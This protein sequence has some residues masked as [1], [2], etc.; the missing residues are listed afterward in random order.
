M[1]R[2]AGAAAA[3]ARG[4]GTIAAL[5]LFIVLA[6]GGLRRDQ[7]AELDRLRNAG[8]RTRHCVLFVA[9][10]SGWLC[11]A[12]LS[13]GAAVG[14]GAAALLAR[15][16]GEPAGAILT[17][18]VITPQGRSRWD[19]VARG[20]HAAQRAG[21]GAQ[22]EADRRA[23]G[24]GGVGPGGS[25]GREHRPRPRDGAAARA[26]VLCSR[27]GADVS[28]RSGGAAGERNAW[29]G[30]ARCSRASRSSISPAPPRL[31]ALVIAFIAV[32]DGPRRL[33]PRLP[34]DADPQR[35]RPGGRPR[36]ADALVS[37]G[38]DFNTPLEVAPLQRWQALASGPVLPVRRTDANYTSGGGTV[39]VPALGIPAAGLTRIHGWRESD[40]SAP[41]TSARPA[42]RAGRAR[43][44]WPG[45]MLPAGHDIAVTASFLA[46]PRGR[47][48]RG[49]ARS[50]GSDP[51]GRVRNSRRWRGVPACPRAA[52][53]VGTR[54]SGARRS[55][56]SRHHE[57]PPER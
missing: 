22:R 35:G 25:A 51:A 53:T 16:E 36:P 31:P 56:G 6:G 23:R 30:A 43:S 17:H 19:R 7:R 29:H 15:G 13:V 8:A 18:S 57:R 33:R 55:H 41:L 37:P 9:A 38:P 1:P 26:A 40:G 42:P 4:R 34:V 10:E 49:P 45:P 27:R 32:A 3:A 44:G 39:T 21:T 47:R 5:A 11:A 20:D 54:G 14:I 12:A 46:E 52:R 24:R 48:D 2:R 28:R 50:P